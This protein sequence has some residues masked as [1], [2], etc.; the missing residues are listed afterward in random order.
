MV[1][2]TKAMIMAGL[3]VLLGVGNPIQS[4]A[5]GAGGRSYVGGRFAL[6]LDGKSVG[7]LH[8]VGGGGIVA[9]VVEDPGDPAAGVTKHIGQ[10]K[11][12]D[13]SIGAGLD[14]DPAF[15]DWL[16][17]TI[18]GA[19]RHR[20]GAI[21]S[22]DFRRDVQRVKEFTDAL[23]TEVG[24]P[25]LDGAAKEP[26]Y[27]SVKF[28]PETAATLPGKGDCPSPTPGA[29]QK[30]WLCSN[31]RLKIG[32]LPC[33][34]VNKI[35]ALVVKQKVTESPVG[36][37]RD[38]FREPGKI[39]YPNLKITVSSTSFDD[40]EKWSRTFMVDGNNG[41]DQELDGSI[42]YL[43]PD[44]KTELAHLNLYH[45]GVFRISDPYFQSDPALTMRFTVELYCEAMEFTVDATGPTVLV[46]SVFEPAIPAVV[47]PALVVPFAPP[48]G[49]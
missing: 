1:G 47:P 23:I 49:G 13:I 7:S 9:P 15:Y 10:P 5:Q 25:A 21:V 40:W 16:N 32:D 33:S 44:L 12:E 46:P 38:Y 18:M 37:A 45:L 11:F 29:R 28:S 36:E 27:L 8:S 17:E 20:N 3:I 35:E 48:L 30:A 26:A 24:F 2:K 39:D 42:T 14:M 34:R 6:T 22:C 43:A 31:F 41:Q 19:A 4:T